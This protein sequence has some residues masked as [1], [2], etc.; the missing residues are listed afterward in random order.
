MS[1]VKSDYRSGDEKRP[2]TTRL[3]ISSQTIIEDDPNSLDSVIRYEKARLRCKLD[4][5]LV[6]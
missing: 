6:I 3:D 5:F 1:G 2:L 4:E